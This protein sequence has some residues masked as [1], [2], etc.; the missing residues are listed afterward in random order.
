MFQNLLQLLLSKDSSN[1]FLALEILKNFREIDLP[2]QTI[3]GLLAFSRKQEITLEAENTLIRF[4]SKKQ[5]DNLIDSL[6]VFK[7]THGLFEHNS[8]LEVKRKS[9]NHAIAPYF[10]HHEQYKTLIPLNNYFLHLYLRTGIFGTTHCKEKYPLFKIFYEAVLQYYPTHPYALFGLANYYRTKDQQAEK[11]LFYYNTFIENY[12]NL[13]PNQEVI[14]L[15]KTATFNQVDL[16]TT[17]NAHQHLANYYQFNDKNY[18]VAIAHYQKANELSPSNISLNFAN[19]GRLVWKYDQDFRAA[20]AI[21]REGL[22]VLNQKAFPTDIL[23]NGLTLFE[24]EEKSKLQKLIKDI[25]QY[26]SSKPSR[27]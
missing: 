7:N 20:L 6:L 19:W 12:P 11:C 5:L 27:N 2:I 8:P 26:T 1:V 16:P 10:N 22:N 25:H 15:Y 13:R 21:A 4:I 24:Y 23:F 17:F 3:L 18:P 14:D 9:V